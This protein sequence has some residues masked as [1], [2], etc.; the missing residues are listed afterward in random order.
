MNG[1]PESDT[2]TKEHEE[3][4][5]QIP[6]K[7]RGVQPLKED[8]EAI[9]PENQLLPLDFYEDDVIAQSA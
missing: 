2:E 6:F 4:E 1:E 9:K 3:K 7:S 8:L 5:T